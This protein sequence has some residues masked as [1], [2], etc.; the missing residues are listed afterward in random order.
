MCD[1]L[2]GLTPT[3]TAPKEKL[4]DESYFKVDDLK[5]SFFLDCQSLKF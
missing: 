2:T 3:A 1:E 4:F 5:V